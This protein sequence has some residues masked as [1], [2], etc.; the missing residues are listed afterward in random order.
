MTTFGR[1]T[2]PRPEWLAR[3]S[4]EKIVDPELPIIDTHHH[5]WPATSASSRPKYE[6]EEYLADTATGHKIIASVYVQARSAYRSFGPEPMRPVG[7]TEWA[8]GTAAMSESGAFGPTR[9]AAGIVGYADLSAGDWVQPVLEAHIA[10]GGGR[11]RGVRDPAAWD[12]DPA[13]G[14][15]RVSAPGRYL[16]D[17]FQQGFRRLTALGLS[18]DAWCFFTQIPDVTVLARKFP[19][20]NII[21]GHF[22]G[23]LGYATYRNR[24]NEVFAQWRSSMTEL[25]R[26]ENVSVKLGG[27]MMR[28]ASF[29]YEEMD[30]PPTGRQLA[31]AWGP[32][33]ETCL[34][35][36]GSSRCVVESNFPVDK[37]GIGYA[38]Y[39]NGLK[40]ALG[41]LSPDEK[42]QVLSGTARRVYRLDPELTA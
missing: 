39:F 36:F 26:S 34:E 3:A 22:G 5:L 25:A 12:A 15:M 13:V 17:D 18:L 29:D 11:F 16:R 35:L 40:L 21:L 7:E 1:V 6:L 14:L 31:T 2:A 27:V 20:S 8:S 23:P 19:T 41:G 32:Y 33:I 9:V 28:L 30:A 10:R 37:V 38:A 4:P 42:L 24:R